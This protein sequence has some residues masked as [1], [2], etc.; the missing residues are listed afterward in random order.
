MVEG[1]VEWC[2]ECA[3]Y[4]EGNVSIASKDPI[5]PV[6]RVVR[7]VRVVQNRVVSSYNLK[8]KGGRGD[9]ATLR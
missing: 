3:G 6:V 9:T 4:I 8:V 7:V 5:D 2:E 1:V